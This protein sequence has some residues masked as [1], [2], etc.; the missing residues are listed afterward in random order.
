MGEIK[1]IMTKKGQKMAF[2]Q[3]EDLYGRMEVIF[4]PESFASN[5][6]CLKESISETEPVVLTAELELKEETPKL[7]ARK[8]EKAKDAHAGR[9]KTVVIHLSP[10]NINTGQLRALK[11]TLMQHRG[12]CPVRIEFNDQKYRTQLELPKG[13]TVAGTSQMV[14]AVKNVFKADVVELR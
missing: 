9:A 2:T 12:K 7:F 11:K 1:E 3:L 10:E 14:Q 4:F 13:M 5:E 8:I 6:G